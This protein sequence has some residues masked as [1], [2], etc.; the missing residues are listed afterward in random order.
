MVVVPLKVFAPPNETVPVLPTSL[1]MMRLFEP[2][3]PAEAIIPLMVKVS[4]AG[5]SMSAVPGTLPDVGPMP[6]PRAC[7]H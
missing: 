2:V 1:L 7:R 5:A 4:E 3:L 6:T